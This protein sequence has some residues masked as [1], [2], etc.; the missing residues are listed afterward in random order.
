MAHKYFDLVR[1]D[2]ER[3]LE[4]RRQAA[5]EVPIPKSEVHTEVF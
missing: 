1:E 5:E 2:V 4:Q 3:E